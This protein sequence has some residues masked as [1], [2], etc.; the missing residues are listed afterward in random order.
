MFLGLAGYYYKFVKDFVIIAAPLTNLLRKNSFHW[1]C[2][3]Q[4]FDTLKKPMTSTPVLALPNFFETFVGECDIAEPGLGKVHHQNNRPI[5][6]FS[7]SL[8]IH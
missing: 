5:A 1:D 8:P 2:R 7:Q 6:F 3:A 4:A